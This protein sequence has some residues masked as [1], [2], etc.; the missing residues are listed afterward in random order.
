MTD[1]LVADASPLLAIIHGEPGSDVAVAAMLEAPDVRI[2]A[3]NLAEVAAKLADRNI[4]FSVLLALLQDFEIRVTPFDAET[5]ILSGRLRTSTRPGGL[6]LGD[7]ACLATAMLHG[8]A[9]L[10]ADRAWAGLDLDIE[11]IFIR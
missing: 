8:G 6:S 2:S 9:V 3:V 7:R 10:T 4:A 5:A 11:M 1:T